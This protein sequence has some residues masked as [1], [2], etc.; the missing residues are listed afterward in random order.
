[1]SDD[2]AHALVI[3]ALLGNPFSPSYARARARPGASSRV[4]PLDFSAMNVALHGPRTSK[5]ALTE[6]RGDAVRRTA[7]E[8]CIGASSVARDGDD[9]E[10]RIDETTAPWASPLRGTVRVSATSRST[11]VVALDA[12]GRHVWTP[13]VPSARVHVTMTS[14][15]VSFR[16]HAYFDA[17]AGDE[18]LESAFDRWTWWRAPRAARGAAIGFDLVARGG[19]V[20]S[21]SRALDGQGRITTLDPVALT[22]LSPTAWR[23]P[24]EVPS[25][26]A[27]VVRTLTDAPFYARTLVD[28]RFAGEQAI[29]MHETLSLERLRSSWVRTLLPFR[30][31]KG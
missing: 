10:V 3:I 6:R 23:L 29:A 24:R 18:P 30:M 12:R 17:N 13:H 11:E 28:G 5:W 9:I 27:R 26:G 22:R 20:R 19:E 1:M 15:A 21:V 4:E 16:G 14:P 25:Q 31:R 2:D 7:S 8:L